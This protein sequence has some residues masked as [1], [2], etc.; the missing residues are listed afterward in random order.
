M[1]TIILKNSKFLLHRSLVTDSRTDTNIS[2]LVYGRGGKEAAESG[3]ERQRSCCY[4]ALLFLITK[5]PAAF[6]VGL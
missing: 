3:R 1:S 2:Q 5:I 6:K 4:T